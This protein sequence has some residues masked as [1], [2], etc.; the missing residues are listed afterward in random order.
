M[1]SVPTDTAHFS[2]SIILP[3]LCIIGVLGN[4]LI[5][6]A[7]WLDR[8]LH[9]VTNYFLFSLALADLLVCIVVMP[10]SFTVEFHRGKWLSSFE[11]C[12]I[13][14]YSDV[15]LCT[16]SIVH[17][18]VISV[19][20]YL[21][22]S[23]PLEMRN[24]SKTMITLKITFVW[25]VTVLISCPIA[26]AAIIDPTNILNQSHCVIT[27]RYYMIYGSTLAFL[28]PFVIMAVTYFKTTNLLKK[29]ASMLSQTAIQR[30]RGEGLRRTIPR[31]SAVSR[32]LAVVFGCFFVCWTP[33]FAA[34]LAN[35][36]F[37]DKC[38]IPPALSSVFLWLGYVSSIINPLIYTIFNR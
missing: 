3:L 2:I 6:M 26:I 4:F 36:F 32:V 20:R 11:L 33:F 27:N 13:Y 8:R 12:L 14:V 37:G 18:S 16:A 23:K 29:Q 31:K 38:D 21:G 1:Q 10:I 25:M 22:I 15:F 7:I 17:M 19:D 34:N 9:N 35:G 5:C 24:R 30:A 28:V